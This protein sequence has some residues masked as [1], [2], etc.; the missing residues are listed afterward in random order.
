MLILGFL[1]IGLIF[2]CLGLFVAYFIGL[3]KLFQKAGYQGWEAIIPFYNNWILVE[4]SGL[5]WWY[6]LIIILSS[7]GIAT[8][9]PFLIPL[10]SIVANF[11][12]CYNLSLK[13]H[14]DVGFAILMTFFPMIMIPLIGF[15]KSYQYDKNVVVSENGPIKSANNNYYYNN[16]NSDSSTNNFC[17]YCGN[18]ITVKGQRFCSNCGNEIGK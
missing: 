18:P 9:F 7:I 15:S 2:V 3:W 14:K 4:I 6:A 1:G 13:F 17:P 16:I 8:P 11:F 5:A 10:A 12:V